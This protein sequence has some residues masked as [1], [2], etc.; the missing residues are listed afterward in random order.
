TIQ[1]L[2]ES[3]IE[4]MLHLQPV[5]P[6]RIAGWS[7][8]G[9]IA[10]E[11]AYQLIAAGKKVDFIGLID[12]D[13]DYKQFYPE[14]EK[15]NG[16]VFDEMAKLLELLS[17]LDIPSIVMKK[18]I[19]LVK[20]KDY[21]AVLQLVKES[22]DVNN[23]P[24]YSF[25]RNFILICHNMDVASYHYCSPKLPTMI[26]LFSAQDENDRSDFSLGWENMIS[27]G[28]LQIIP[29]KGTHSSIMKKPYIGQL[30]NEMLRVIKSK[31]LSS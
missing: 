7:S 26:T 27:D 29:L 11:I 17:I 13:R 28:L 22:C 25:L 5:G 24:E 1:N 3:Y 9:L 30:G 2:A 6:Y 16:F 14:Y 20:S 4:G 12:T 18:L 19:D 31:D 15:P 10:Y 8:G 23:L 21:A